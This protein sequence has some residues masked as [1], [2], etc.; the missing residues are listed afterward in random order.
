MRFCQACPPRKMRYSCTQ[1]KSDG[2]PGPALGTACIDDTAA[3][4]GTHAGA[5]TVGALALQVTG[6][7]GSF[8][9]TLHPVVYS[10]KNPFLA[11]QVMAEKGAKGTVFN[12][13]LSTSI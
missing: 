2:Q 10:I 8:H 13:V 12:A 11:R 6:L 9:V 4:L 1:G 3:I 5:K 7:I